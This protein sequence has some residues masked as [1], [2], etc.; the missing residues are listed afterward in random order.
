[1]TRK[2]ELLRI[3]DDIDLEAWDRLT[4]NFWLPEKVPLC[5]DIQ[6]WATLSDDE[7]WVTMQVFAGLIPAGHHS[8]HHWR[9]FAAVGR[10]D[11]ARRSRAHQHLL[12]GVGACEVV[13]VDLLA[14]VEHPSDRRSVPPGRRTVHSEQES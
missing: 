11:S 13:F 5:N 2:A 8:G 12:Q 7:K 10:V 1:M 9:G 4:L 3:E 14:P 6:S